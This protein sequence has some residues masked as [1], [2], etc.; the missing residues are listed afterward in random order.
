MKDSVGSS[1]CSLRA[2]S[3]ALKWITAW[4]VLVVRLVGILLFSVWANDC[5]FREF[6]TT[7]TCVNFTLFPY[8]QLMAIIWLLATITTSLFLLLYVR[9]LP[10]FPSFKLIIKHLVKQRYFCKISVVLLLVV[11]YDFLTITGKP[12]FLRTLQYSTFMLEHATGILLMFTLNFVPKFLQKTDQQRRNK[13]LLYKLTLAMYS[14]EGYVLYVLGTMIAVY[15]VLS[16]SSCGREHH[17]K[18]YNSSVDI[19]ASSSV[20]RH[21]SGVSSCHDPKSVIML[22]LLMTNNG[23]RYF[24]GDFFMAKLFSEDS[25]IL[26]G[27]HESID[28]LELRKQKRE[29]IEI[30]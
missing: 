2:I 16:I 26:G 14:L 30:V 4:C 15:K 1:R 3:A 28:S 22:L 24:V 10:E 11:I 13:S 18:S 27:K 17:T 5:F 7:V 12:H 9:R 25:D 21:E 6:R 29:G 19:L 20:H 23:L 8:P